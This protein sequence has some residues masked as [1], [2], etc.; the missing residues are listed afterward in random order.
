MT[1]LLVG[2][3]VRH[4]QWILDPWFDHVETAVKEADV[5][6]QFLFVGDPERDRSFEVIGRRSPD[7]HVEIAPVTTSD[8]RRDW[9]SR[10]RYAQMVELRNQLL[11]AV[12]EEKPDAFLSLDSDILIHPFA[13][14]MLLDDLRTDHWDA[15]GGKCY[16]QPTGTLSPSWA[17]VSYS[18]GLDRSDSTGYFATQVIMAI[19]MMSPTAYGVDYEVHPQGEDIGWSLACERAHL[20]LAW[21]G[22]IASKHV[23]DPRQLHQRDPRVGY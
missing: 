21:D 10:G 6:P 7:A 14:R 2:C 13:V 23:M 17:R 5:T 1:S 18:Q 15:V 9:S 22:R 20:A 4:R 19:K 12:R 16:M 8:D 3:P 11:G